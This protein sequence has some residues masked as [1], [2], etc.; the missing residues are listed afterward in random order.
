MTYANKK[1]ADTAARREMRKIH[2]EAYRAKA[3]V[4]FYVKREAGSFR[5]EFHIINEAAHRAA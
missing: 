4:D 5:W 1:S 3:G 2:G